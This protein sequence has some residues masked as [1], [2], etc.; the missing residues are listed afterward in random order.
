MENIM[1]VKLKDFTGYEL[2]END[3]VVSK[4]GGRCACM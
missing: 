3:L 4:P 1:A 2:K